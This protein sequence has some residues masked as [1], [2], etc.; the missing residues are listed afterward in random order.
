MKE[1]NAIL[2]KAE[3]EILFSAEVKKTLVN[4]L[5]SDIYMGS[6][7]IQRKVGF[8]IVDV[9]AIKSKKFEEL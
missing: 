7:H 9:E 4:I 2:E 1:G 3:K 6:P 8:G 5:K